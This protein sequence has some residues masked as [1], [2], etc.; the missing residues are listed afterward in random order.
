MLKNGKERKVKIIKLKKCRFYTTGASTENS[1]KVLFWKPSLAS[2]SPDFCTGASCSRACLFECSLMLF[3]VRYW[4]LKLLISGA[5]QVLRSLFIRC[6]T[7]P[8]GIPQDQTKPS[9]LYFCAP[10]CHV[11]VPSLAPFAH[12][13]ARGPLL[14]VVA[15]PSVRPSLT[16]P[17]SPIRFVFSLASYPLALSILSCPFVWTRFARLKQPWRAGSVTDNFLLPAKNTTVPRY[18]YAYA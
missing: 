11:C 3:F 10:W 9:G 13:A 5:C 4:H 17:P 2:E 18:V 12:P 16:R 6:L 8:L 7:N 15:A 1:K 14:T